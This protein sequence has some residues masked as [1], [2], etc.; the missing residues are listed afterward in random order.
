V[1][2]P[3]SWPRVIA[4]T[5]RLWV[6]RHVVPAR[7]RTPAGSRPT[8]NGS[9]GSRR[10]RFVGGFVGIA[11]VVGAVTGFAI[12]RVSATPSS[13]HASRSADPATPGPSSTVNS[14]GLT[15]A[16]A[17]RQQTATWVA[18]Q[19]SRGEI[20]G[21]D[22]LMCATLQQH[23]LPPADLATLG[24]SASDPLG[25]GIV[26]STTAVRSQL[27]PRLASVYAPLVIASFGTGASLVQIRVVAPGGMTAYE[28]AERADLTARQLAG[29][30][31]A[32]NKNIQEPAAA[33][34]ALQSGR[35]DSRLLITLAALAATSRVHVSAFS[36]AGPGAGASVPLR[37]LTVVT[38]SPTYLRELLSFL[39]AQRPPLLA[40]VSQHRDG[41][42]TTVQIQ[43]TA[44]S[45]TGLLPASTTQTLAAAG[46]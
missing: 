12:S 6:E 25:S 23:G 45:P 44:P 33:K 1:P 35:V 37:R 13:A 16:A 17:I 36:D 41:R 42:M 14:Q 4:T 20:I 10:Y 5:L 8:A 40:N 15:T 32:G 39:N 30:E 34:A 3:P 9:A 11:V 38:S 26:I 46:S 29:R 21:C 19:V 22:P 28:P 31:L 7:P 27:G 43:F 2:P 18:A 24:A